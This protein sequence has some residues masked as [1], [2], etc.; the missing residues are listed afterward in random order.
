MEWRVV[1]RWSIF[2]KWERNSTSNKNHFVTAH[3]RSLSVIYK[4]LIWEKPVI[5]FS[6]YIP[7]CRFFLKI[8]NYEKGNKTF[9][10]H[11]KIS[12]RIYCQNCLPTM[13]RWKPNVGREEWSATLTS[14]SSLTVYGYCKI[15]VKNELYHDISPLAIIAIAPLWMNGSVSNE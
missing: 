11:V 12:F 4:L 7:L 15:A 10:S 9:M 5:T 1:N 8:L 3:T 6:R 2:R 13:W 14:P